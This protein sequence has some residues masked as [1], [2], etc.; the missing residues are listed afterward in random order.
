MCCTF[1]GI[2]IFRI[3][4][5]YRDRQRAN[6]EILELQPIPIRIVRRVSPRDTV[7]VPIQTPAPQTI[8]VVALSDQRWSR[9]D[10]TSPTSSTTAVDHNETGDL[11]DGVGPSRLPEE[12]RFSR[13]WADIEAAVELANPPAEERRE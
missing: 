10:P 9:T 7:S 6:N 5:H 2:A 8:P 3:V 4:C 11:G 1:I 13:L 12:Y